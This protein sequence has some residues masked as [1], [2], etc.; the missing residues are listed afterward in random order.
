M[1]V[2]YLLEEESEGCVGLREKRGEDESDGCV[3]L[4]GEGGEDESCSVPFV[5]RS[6]IYKW[7]GVTV[8]D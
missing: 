1:I 6:S 8:S 5:N 4:R 7:S 3:E 2:V